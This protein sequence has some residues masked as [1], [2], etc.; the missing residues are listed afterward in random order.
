MNVA[1]GLEC[2][3]LS[4]QAEQAA[5]VNMH[6]AVRGLLG[7][8]RI[9]GMLLSVPLTVVQYIIG[10]VAYLMPTFRTTDIMEML[11]KSHPTLLF[12]GYEH[13]KLAKLN[14][15]AFWYFYHFQHPQHLDTCCLLATTFWYAYVFW[16]QN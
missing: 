11:F 12:G 4:D 5:S 10:G 16:G 14:N 3:T 15:L 8:F 9:F 13:G 1:M 2:G 7:K 6:N